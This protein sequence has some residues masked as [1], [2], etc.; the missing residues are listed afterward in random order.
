MCMFSIFIDKSESI[1]YDL[2]KRIFQRKKT[3]EASAQRAEATKKA[4]AEAQKAADAN[5]TNKQKDEAEQ[6]E[7]QTRADAVQKTVELREELNKLFVKQ[8]EIEKGIQYTY[9]E[10][11]NEYERKSYKEEDEL[12]ARLEKEHD[13]EIKQLIEKNRIES[14]E[15][16]VKKAAALLKVTGGKSVGGSGKRKADDGVGEASSSDEPSMKKQKADDGAAV[17][18]GELNEANDDTKV[19]DDDDGEVKEGEEVLKSA[20]KEQELNKLMD[21]MSQ[22]NKTK[23]QMIWL[24]K[25][26]SPRLYCF[27]SCEFVCSI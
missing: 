13:E 24:L 16:K 27:V 25:Q 3:W 4:L 1:L 10:K 8:A 17:K 5:T 19:D 26:E 11:I 20:L 15:D 2:I 22:L 9:K 18:T 21:E 23:S 12:M 7:K 6:R 14:E